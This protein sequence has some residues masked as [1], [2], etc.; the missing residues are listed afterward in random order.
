M[1]TT[2]VRFF[3][4]IHAAIELKIVKESLANL[5]TGKDCFKRTGWMSQHERYAE[6]N[7]RYRA[8]AEL[9]KHNDLAIA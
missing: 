7:E 8:V 2:T 4:H 6:Q 5:K 1:D 3:Q 9:A